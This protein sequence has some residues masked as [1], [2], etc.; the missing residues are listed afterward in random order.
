MQ[1]QLDRLGLG[2]KAE[3]MFLSMLDEIHRFVG[4]ADIT[5]EE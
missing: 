1:R 3:E 2:A 5:D 4:G